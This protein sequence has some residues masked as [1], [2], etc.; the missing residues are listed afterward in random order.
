MSPT[1][2]SLK[3]L[4]EAGYSA[5]V[6]EKWVP[7]SPA[8]YKGP[9]ITRDA[10]NFGDILAVR[11]GLPG[12]TLVQTTTASN[13]AAR[14]T[15]IHQI[16]EAGIWLAAGNRIVVHGW[17][18]SGDRG[19]RKVWSCRIQVIESITSPTSLVPS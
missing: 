12:A 14:I 19:K 17:R 9:I 10:W 3:L 16:A 15:K 4:R 18:K 11:I 1:E 7:S 13:M 6:V 2:R 8:G 5:C